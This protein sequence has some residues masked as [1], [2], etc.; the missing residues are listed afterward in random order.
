MGTSLL[1]RVYEFPASILKSVIVFFDVV[2]FAWISIRFLYRFGDIVTQVSRGMS[3]E[4]MDVIDR[5]ALRNWTNEGR[6]LLP[7]QYR[8]ILE[9]LVEESLISQDAH[10][11]YLQSTAVTMVDPGLGKEVGFEKIRS[12]AENM[13]GKF[14]W[15][16][17]PL[18][19]QRASGPL[20]SKIET[21]DKDYQT[22]ASFVEAAAFIQMMYPPE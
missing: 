13:P 18:I 19:L 9:Q 2:R 10:T 14:P 3:P 4:G 16:D 15:A 17:D 8:L 21:F 7:R 11:S 6:H 20:R 5:E 12:I 1:R 22:Y